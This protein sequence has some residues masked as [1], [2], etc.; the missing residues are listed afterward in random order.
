M[1]ALQVLPRVDPKNQENVVLGLL[2]V[3]A[4]TQNGENETSC[5]GRDIIIVIACD[6]NITPGV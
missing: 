2:L 1:L 4:S 5:H 3:P 6:N